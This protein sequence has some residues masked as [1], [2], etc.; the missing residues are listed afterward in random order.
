VTTLTLT[1]PSLFDAV[2]GEPTLDELLV[3]MWEGLTAH[4]AV[5]CPVCGDRMEP[6][7]GVHA[8]PIGG[9]CKHCGAT[10]T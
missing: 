3:G 8:L 10:L 7:Y 6:D 2:A 9:R 5:R 1:P 4:G